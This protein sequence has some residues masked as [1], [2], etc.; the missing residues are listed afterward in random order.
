MRAGMKKNM[1]CVLLAGLALSLVPTAALAQDEAGD[2]PIMESDFDLNATV[3]VVSDYRFRGISLSN[4]KPAGQASL[5]IE[6][7][8]GVYA[9][10][11]GS[12]IA[13]F[14]GAR[15]EVDLY[16]GWR[17]SLGPVDLDVGGTLYLYPNGDSIN[18]GEVY[19][20]LGKTIG[21]AELRAGV[22][23]APKQKNIGSDDNVYVVGQGRVGIPGTPV[24]VLGVVGYEAGPLAG[25]DGDKVD[26]TLGGEYVWKSV[27]LGISYV[28]TDVRRIHDPA[29]SSRPAVV[30]SAVLGF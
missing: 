9:G 1:S 13:K 10:V 12:T 21:P 7:K 5:D 14:A 28:D 18:Y 6:H 23:Y 27:T 4:R 29:R 25:L 26:W 16:A 15:T 17:K 20:Y 24:T 2:E 11:W 8:S 30:T 19:G 3:S 22:V